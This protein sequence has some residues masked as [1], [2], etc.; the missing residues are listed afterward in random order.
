ME[1][2][3]YRI[4]P[5]QLQRMILLETGSIGCLFV[6]AWTGVQNGLLIVMFSIIGSLIYGGLLMAIGRTDGG[7]FAITER[8]LHGFLWRLIW[9]IY[10]LRFTIRGAW[11]LSYM[12]Y[13]IKETLFD[14]SRLMIILP[15]LLICAYAGMRSLEGRA[16]FVELLFWWIILPLVVLFLVGLWKVDLANLSPKPNVDIRQVLQGEYQLMALFLPLEFLLFRMSAMEGGNRKAWNVGM[17]GILS[18]GMWLLLVYVVTVGILGAHWGHRSLLGVTEAMELISIKGGGLERIDILMILIWL[19]GGIITLSAYIFQGQQLLRRIVPGQNRVVPAAIFM[20]LLILAAYFCFPNVQTWTDWY[21][22]YA[23]LIDFPL[24]VILPVIIW[25]IYRI[26][27]RRKRP[28]VLTKQVEPPVKEFV[29]SILL[30]SLCVSLTTLTGCAAQDSIEDRTYVE[31]LHIMPENDKYQYRCTIAYMDEES[32]ENLGM[33]QEG[34][35]SEEGTDSG[36]KDKMA[37]TGEYAAVAE[38]INAFNQEYYRKTGH[39]FDYSH[40]RGI[41]LD[42]AFYQP[43]LAEKILEDVRK[44]TKVVLSTPIYQEGVEIGVQKEETLGEW[45]KEGGE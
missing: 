4:S 36:S 12:E 40:L 2:A 29:K 38:G 18:A 19:I 28:Q 8:S 16:R 43:A 23:C 20:T 42:S 3:Q 30:V 5:R 33:G 27:S 34:S 6:T 10:I 11:I 32:A 44:E 45:L 15:L 25:C 14:G 21:W 13:L 22:R 7:F 31:S 17:K 1:E 35:K 37:S 26:R 9:L 39:S 24:S 41:Y